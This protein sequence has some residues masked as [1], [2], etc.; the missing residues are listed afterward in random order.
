MP[1][2]FK[3]IPYIHSISALQNVNRPF[4][5]PGKAIEQKV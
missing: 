2:S 3:R 5:L 1:P 4:A